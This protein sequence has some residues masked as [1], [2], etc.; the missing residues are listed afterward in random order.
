MRMHWDARR[1]ALLILCFWAGDLMAQSGLV[2]NMTHRSAPVGVDALED[3]MIQLPPSVPDPIEPFNRAMWGFNRGLM[4]W[5]VKPTGKVYR[6]IIRK[7]LRQGIANFGRNVTY[8]G[9]LL[10]NLLQGRWR[11]A[12]DESDRFLCN[13]L[14]GGAGFVDVATRWRIPKSD[15]DFGQTFGRW[16]W[17]PA[18]YL[19]LPVFGPSNERDALGLACDSAADPLHYVTPQSSGREGALSFISPYTFYTYGV[20]YNNLTD[21]VDSYVRFARAEADPYAMLQYAWTFARSQRTPDLGLHGETDPASLDTLAST[22]VSFKEL[23]FPGRGQTKSIK[24]PSTGNK[25]KF[26]LWLQPKRAPIVY[27]VPGLGS[28]RLTDMTLALA[29]LAYQKGNSVVCV[30]SPYNPE[31]MDHASTAAVPGYTP[32]DAHDLHVAL[33]EVDRYLVRRHPERISARALMG[34][35]MGGF[36]TLFLAGSEKA[37]DA[38]LLR[39]D[40]FVAVNAPVRLSYGISRLDEFYNAPLAWPAHQRTANMENTLL[41]IASSLQG[42]QVSTSAVPYSAI[43]SKF[44]IGLSFR[45]KLRDVIFSSQQRTNLGVLE[46]PIRSSRRGPV[47][48]EILRYSFA[49]YLQRFAVPYYH[50]RGV[51]LAAPGALDRAGDLRTYSGGLQ[52]NTKVW[53]ITNENDFLLPREDLDWLRTSFR[54]DQITVFGRGGHMGNLGTAEVLEAIARAL[55]GL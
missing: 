11:G 29:E 28:H 44:L 25:L 53:I 16:G 37:S 10:N 48:D 47:Y 5:V 45:L 3:G 1:I 6:F 49:E 36:H 51:D 30:S 23:G 21:S 41:K 15:A 18:L 52:G 35:S 54:T 27:L 12:M 7:P 32:V 24:I 31:F 9:R 8:P 13:T 39:F 50:S 17:N 33:T 26:S 2:T 4:T 38:G 22:L 43:E 42:S 20:T 40:R 19:M 46:Q 34:Y 55:Q 14:A